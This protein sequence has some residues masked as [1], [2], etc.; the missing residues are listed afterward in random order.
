MKYQ[1]R[2]WLTD[3]ARRAGQI[4][5]VT[6]AAKFTHGDAKSSSIYCETTD[7]G[8]LSTA[9]LASVATMLSETPL[10]MGKAAA[11]RRRR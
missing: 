1:P 8:Y 4:S 2:T 3:A 10:W 9:T 7:E 5:L 6:H 11:N